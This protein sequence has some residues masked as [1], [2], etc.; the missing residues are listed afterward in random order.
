MKFYRWE[1][2]RDYYASYSCL[3]SYVASA[4][5]IQSMHSKLNDLSMI[6]LFNQN[7]EEKF[8]D[9]KVTMKE[10]ALQKGKNN[11]VDSILFW[12]LSM[13]VCEDILFFLGN[14]KL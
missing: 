13:R 14:Y 6:L 12:K 7:L 5:W 11:I 8:I 3:F 10:N 9:Y 2:S 4:N 1:E